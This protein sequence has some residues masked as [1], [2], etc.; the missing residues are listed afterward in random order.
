MRLRC[1][2]RFLDVEKN[3]NFNY[4]DVE[5][6]PQINLPKNDVETAQI[7]SQLPEGILSK[8]TARSLFSFMYNP[9]RE[10]QLIDEEMKKEMDNEILDIHAKEQDG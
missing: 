6:R 9:S 5:I 2:F 3:K 7:I 10:Q 1:L 4:K 8:Q